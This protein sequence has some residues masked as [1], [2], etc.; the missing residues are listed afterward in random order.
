MLRRTAKGGSLG[1]TLR[2][3]AVHQSKR[4]TG[5]C[6]TQPA[7]GHGVGRVQAKPGRR[8]PREVYC[9]GGGLCCG[10]LSLP[11]PKSFWTGLR[12]RF[13]SAGWGSA[14]AGDGFGAPG[15]GSD[16]PLPGV[17]PL[18]VP[19]PIR[20]LPSVWGIHAHV[21]AG[22]LRPRC[23]S[24]TRQG[25]CCWRRRRHGQVCGPVDAH[26]FHTIR[27]DKALH[28]GVLRQADGAVHELGPDGCGGVG[29]L[30]LA[31]EAGGK[32]RCNRRCRPR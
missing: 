18:G 4:G 28:V 24:G 26:G 17:Q 13:G 32:C 27:S 14:G 6:A 23:R 21:R 19:L 12:W 31:G 22:A 5:A 11:K 9:G 8:R 20:P 25:C 3:C 16:A 2:Q 7:R 1:K 30:D 29:A 10:F 15:P